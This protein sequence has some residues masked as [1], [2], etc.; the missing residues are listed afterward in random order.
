MHISK[1]IVT[2]IIDINKFFFKA[3]IYYIYIE[4]HKLEIFLYFFI[5]YGH[6]IFF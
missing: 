3:M 5:K 2:V 1:V 4:L 6:L